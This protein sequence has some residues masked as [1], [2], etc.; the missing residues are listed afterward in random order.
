MKN[1]ICIVIILTAIPCRA[2]TITVDD[3]GQAA[4]NDPNIVAVTIIDC[5]NQAPGCYLG[6]TEDTN[7][8]L[9]ALTI[10]HCNASSSENGS[11]FYSKLLI[12]NR[13]LTNNIRSQRE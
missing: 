3:N 6:T 2:R 13:T 1:A 10:A 4:I 9:R 11:S 12:T 5:N 8:I 7:S